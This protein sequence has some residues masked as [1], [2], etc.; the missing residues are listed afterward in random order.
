MKKVQLSKFLTQ[1]QITKRGQKSKKIIDWFWKESVFKIGLL[2][3]VLFF[4]L[5]ILSLKLPIIEILL[6]SL[7]PLG[8][9]LAVVIFIKET[10]ERKKQFNYQALSTIDRAS[11][12]RNS[13]ARIIALQDLVDQAI[14]L[15]ELDLFDSNLEGI[16][17]NGIEIKNGN[18][19]KSN[20]RKAKMH[21][22][23]LQK[24][25]FEFAEGAGVN[26]NYGN[27]SFCNLQK[28]NFNNSDFSNSNLMFS[29]FENAKLSGTKFINSK[30]KGAKFK[31]AFMIGANFTGAEVDIKELEKG[32]LTN[33]IMPD[34]SKHD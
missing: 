23:N 21:L 18:F 26:I 25:N 3:S 13:K 31:N 2:V 8:V 12:I 16:E 27:L 17:L 11:G 4:L 32:I 24:S 33:A 15:D 6:S 1:K 22:A 19:K 34:G 20:I 14:N 9:L 5:T 30:L 29:N 28:S 10:P 7:E